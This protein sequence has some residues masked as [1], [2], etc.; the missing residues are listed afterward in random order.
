[1]FAYLGPPL[2]LWLPHPA[3]ILS[4]NP[5]SFVFNTSRTQSLLNT[6]IFNTLVQAT[7]IPLGRSP[8]FCFVLF[9][10]ILHWWTREI[11]LHT[12][13]ILP[14]LCSNGLSSHSKRTP[15]QSSGRACRAPQCLLPPLS[16]LIYPN[17]LSPALFPPHW[18]PGSSSNS[19]GVLLLQSHCVFQNAL[20]HLV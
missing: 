13:Q 20:F 10:S 5:F 2:N 16:D 7:V 19:R 11:R 6:F 18:A 15:K 9:W 3:S 12:A 4:A 1:M 14:F 8:C 17:I